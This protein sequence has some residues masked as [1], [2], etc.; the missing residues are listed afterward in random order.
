M[1][2]SM[3]ASLFVFA[4][5]AF[6]QASGEHWVATW[7]TAQQLYRA[8][9]GRGAAAP[10]APTAPPRPA[11]GPQRRFGIPAPLV[12]VNNETIRM[13][14]HTSI[15]GRSVRIRLQ[16]ALGAGT[17][18]IGA[19][20][21]AIRDKDSAIVK[22]TDRELTFSGKP[23]ALLYAGETL[24]SDPVS[25]NVAP[26]AHV[27]VSLFIPGQAADP[28]N[29][30]FALHTTYLSKEGDFTGEREIADA[31]TRE[32]Y[33]WLAGIDVL[34]PAAASALVTFG[35]SITDGDQS[36][37]E[38]DGMWPDVLA[39]RLQSSK[40]TA[41]IAVVN[42]G[43]SGNRILGDN[44][45]G[46]VRLYHDALSQPGIK[47]MSILEG[48][49]D[50]TGGARVITADTLIAAYRQ[51]IE[52]AH[53]HNVKVIGCTITPY[54]GSNVYNEYGESVRSA[55]NEW[56]RTGGAFDAV[57]DFDAATRDAT[58]P[59]RF[60]AEA[61]SPDMLHPAN[62]G[63]KLMGEAF[64]AAFTKAVSGA[65]RATTRSRP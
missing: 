63:Y 55:V 45:S 27:A 54:G 17:V 37:P 62:P 46:L 43:I 9:G 24:I 47:W 31:T 23:T 44:Q 41:N 12:A 16:N 33:Y 8:G 64:S 39:A 51:M 18:S 34:A 13:I 21:I 49:N 42:A 48:I 61:D 20:H 22:G 35:D 30:R 26:L 60:R 14:A 5:P 3:L 1:R 19:A 36:T 52:A 2:L 32:S 59:T 7:A 28:A 38:T 29:H 15:G 4:F 53:Q 6:S 57:V 58:D 11:T 25:L 65:S 40:A 50:I 56:I 10:A